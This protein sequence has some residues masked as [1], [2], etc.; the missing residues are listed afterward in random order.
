MQRSEIAQAA[1]AGLKVF[2]K[3]IKSIKTTI[4]FD[5]FVDSIIDVVKTREDA[6]HYQ[7]VSTISEYGQRIVAA[8]GKSANIELVTKLRK[9][10][11][12][13]P[14]MANAM[15]SFGL[16]IT[17]IGNL[18]YPNIDEV[19]EDFAKIAT[20]HSIADPGYTDALE[21]EDGKLLMGKYTSTKEINKDT[22]AKIIGLDKFKQITKDSRFLGMV[23]W[24]MLPN[25]NSIWDLLI[26]D[27][28]PAIGSDVNGKKRMIFI[29]L[30]DPAKRTRQ[31]IADALGRLTQMSPFADVVLGLN[32]AESTQVAQ[33]LNI[34]VQDDAESEIEFTA[35][36]IRE[37]L[38][39]K[40]VVIHPRRCAAA[41]VL[42]KDGVTQARFQGPFVQ[43]PKLSTGAGD[44]FNAG[45]CLGLLADL[46]VAQALCVGTASSGFY[47]RNA[48]SATLD[49]LIDFCADLPPAE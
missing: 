27:I 20:V 4:G 49:Q 45:F 23:N 24:T 15:A 11:G 3:T 12:N 13:G 16:P 36:R 41:A 25:L 44:N 18:G 6:D 40:A 32:L 17:Y 47:V 14:I 31:D 9:L 5:G 19:F 21:F 22:I 46:P 8:A 43:K 2:S 38:N 26:S 10:G 1:S 34:T 35:Q 39:L 48:G 33:V 37:K 30:A 42:T 29:D 7:P 28:L